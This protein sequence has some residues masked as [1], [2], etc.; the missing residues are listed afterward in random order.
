M[1]EYKYV[2][3]KL[4]DYQSSLKSKIMVKCLELN[5]SATSKYVL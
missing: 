3:C 5:S 2:A 4:V 1:V